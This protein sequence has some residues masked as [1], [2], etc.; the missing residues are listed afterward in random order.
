MVVSP[1]VSCLM[2]IGGILS[3]DP[4]MKHIVTM[5]IAELLMQGVQEPAA[6]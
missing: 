4:A 2:H 3:R 1:D 6:V 5:H